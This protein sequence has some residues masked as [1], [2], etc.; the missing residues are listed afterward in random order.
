[1]TVTLSRWRPRSSALKEPWIPG[2]RTFHVGRKYTVVAD[3][4]RGRVLHTSG[5]GPHVWDGHGRLLSTLPT[6]EKRY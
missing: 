3:P 5:H 1:M 6:S 2:F 4:V